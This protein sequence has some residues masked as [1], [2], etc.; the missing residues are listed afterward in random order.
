M[1]K[2]PYI[3]GAP[4]T[5][6]E[7]FAPLRSHPADYVHPDKFE[8]SDLKTFVVWMRASIRKPMEPV[9]FR[10]ILEEHLMNYLRF[11]SKVPQHRHKHNYPY[12]I[13]RFSV[14]LL[15]L[16]TWF[17]GTEDGGGFQSVTL[18]DE[19]DGDTLNEKRIYRTMKG[20]LD[21]KQEDT[22]SKNPPSRQDKNWRAK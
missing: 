2:E 12:I 18:S 3:C 20:M 16:I 11:F 1:S 19:E 21:S 7:I 13:E 6:P 14:K 22:W 17:K 4:S 8:H 10:D 5:V 9:A 15:A